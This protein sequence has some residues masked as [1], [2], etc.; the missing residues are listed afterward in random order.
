VR[1]A[2]RPLGQP[3]QSTLA[4]IFRRLLVPVPET[5]E[6]VLESCQFV[7][8]VRDAREHNPGGAPRRT[9]M[10]KLSI[11]DDQG[12]KTVVSLLREE[13]SIGRS[14]E[15]TVRLTERN[16]S[17]HHASIRKA[18]SGWVL[19]DQASYNGCFINGARV[20]E[21]RLLNHGDLLQLGDYRLEIVDESKATSLS[22]SSVPPGR[23]PIASLTGQPD[24]LVMVVGPTPGAEFALDED[25]IVLGRG[26]DSDVPISH[27]SVSRL[28]AEIRQLGDGRFEIIDRESAN[29]VRVNGI[30]LKRALLDARDVIELGD[31]VFKFIPAGE[32]YRPTADEQKRLV[33]ISQE[34]ASA[35]PV[36]ATAAARTGVSPALKAVAVIAG[37][38]VVV[39]LL[40][41]TL[42]DR[43]S[44]ETPSA[45]GTA[46]D[47]AVRILAMAKAALQRGEM[48][49]A[50]LLAT[51]GVP[52]TSNARQAPDFLEIEAEWADMLFRQADREDEREKKRTLLDRVAK[53]ASVDSGR[54][55]R[56]ADLIAGL[57]GD[58]L[59]V[60]ALPSQQKPE[61]ELA[62]TP[63]TAAPAPPPA[64]APRSVSAQSVAAWNARGRT[65]G[66]A[67][68]VKGRPTAAFP[69]DPPSPSQP[70]AP[71]L[72]PGV[73]PKATP[74]PKT[75]PVNAVTEQATSGD[76]ASQIAAKDALKS[77]VA[78]GHASEQEKRLLRALCRQFSDPSCSN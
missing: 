28:H 2:S 44:A 9:P 17:R 42:S 24:R 21:P 48:E 70:A 49:K 68:A 62:I 69:T 30:E 52:E 12:H 77:K 76:R 6:S 57:D 65:L 67:A 8:E 43:Q 46:M 50:H 38:A 27:A 1:V 20:A 25:R 78:G 3:I 56:A 53:T 16:I 41:L 37:L 63:S 29:G 32:V 11:E 40:T 33:A 31:I 59:D 5:L 45:S 15:N 61:V 71:I 36:V 14:H 35:A 60:A 18:E 13:Y 26:E 74:L 66:P 58:G 51:N 7:P 34:P 54:R 10:W 22:P 23:T 55:K 39:A 72:P 4:R 73:T 19:E 75:P 64:N 47:D